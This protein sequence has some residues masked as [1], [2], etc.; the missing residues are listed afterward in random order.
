MGVSAHNAIPAGT[1]SFPGPSAAPRREAGSVV[2]DRFVVCAHLGQCRYGQVYEAIDR[3]WS[4][5]QLGLE[6]HVALHVLDDRIRSQTRLLRK[7]ES[8]YLQPHLWTHPNI[9]QIRGFG[10]DQGAYYL[11]TELL[12]G[13][14]LRSVLDELRP[15]LP[16]PDTVF[17]I[18]HAVGAALTY[19]HGNNVVHGDIRPETIFVSADRT[20][21]VLDLLPASSARS[22]PFFVEDTAPNGLF[23]PDPLDDVYGLA[24]LAYELLAGVHPYN[25][26]SALEALNDG[27]AP[28]PIPG[29]APQRWVALARGLAL[30]RAD[31]RTSVGELLVGLRLRQPLDQTA[32]SRATA[33]P[34]ASYDERLGP[35]AEIALIEDEARV[36]A[37]DAETTRAALE[38]E[39]DFRATQLR[40]RWLPSEP[41]IAP[42]DVLACSTYARRLRERR[43]ER[44]GERHR[45]A[46]RVPLLSIAGLAALG[47]AAYQAYQEHGPFRDTVGQLFAA[48]QETV[49]LRDREARGTALPEPEASAAAEPAQPSTASSAIE[50]PGAA[51]AAEP[52][53]APAAAAVEPLASIPADEPPATA[54]DDAAPASTGPERFELT[55]QAAT[56]SESQASAVVVIERRGGNLEPASVIWWASDGTAVAGEDYADLGR[57]TATFEAGERTRTILVPIVA[58]FVIEDR[59][60]FYVNMAVSDTAAT[61][62]VP[63]QRLEIVI[64]DDD[65]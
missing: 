51:E 41:V 58:D 53:P 28:V 35:D 8:C 63:G 15:G 31:R 3:A 59:E 54:A 12:E 55:S 57:Q 13:R 46:V 32:S 56:V 20:V 5:G 24:C 52:G 1:G 45:F 49:G 48:A 60:S 14:S 62:L 9:V 23:C 7:L 18:L 43:G 17:T 29:L 4:D 11:S 30:R 42:Q 65:R 10:A 47:V 50:A 64:V 34:S 33:P 2:A 21:K 27:V 26:A 16:S 25:G 61:P 37:R 36:P 6:Q 22:R 40:E 39:P 19:A 44:R 38:P